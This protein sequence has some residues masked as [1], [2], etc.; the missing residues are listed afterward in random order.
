MLKADRAA[1][2]TAF[3]EVLATPPHWMSLP[4]REWP[5]YELVVNLLPNSPAVLGLSTLPAEEQPERLAR[6][7]A[8][9]ARG[10]PRFWLHESG[11]LTGRILGNETFAVARFYNHARLEV[12]SAEL[13][14][15]ASLEMAFLSHLA[16]RGQADI[17]QAF[18]N[19]HVLRWLPALGRSLSTCGDS[20]YASVGQLLADFLDRVAMPKDREADLHTCS[21]QIPALDLPGSCTLCG[22]CVQRCPASALFID[23]TEAA[24]R[25][26]LN[27]AQC[28][29][30]GNCISAC[31]DG[32]LSLT[33]NSSAVSSVALV[34]SERVSC[35]ACGAPTV[36]RAEINYLIQKIGHPSWL[37]LCL[38]CRVTVPH[39][40][41]K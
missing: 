6:Y 35:S 2:Y 9:F 8:L 19:L 11:Y 16:E 7:E 41:K 1:L 10:C 27:A 25:L 36:S 22:F 3:A 38:T 20:L 12:N 30:C 21:M 4:G 5:L 14:D 24:T 34:E 13:P 39:G 31:Q 26:R 18:L 28:N 40:G 29:G 37:D 32:L 23:E 33:S 15:H 17:E